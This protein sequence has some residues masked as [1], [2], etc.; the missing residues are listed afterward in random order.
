[1]VE[2]P[3]L[4]TAFIELQWLCV[5]RPNALA[6]MIQVLAKWSYDATEKLDLTG[7]ALHWFK[8]SR[9]DKVSR[10]SQKVCLVVTS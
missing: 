5:G 3:K 4:T 6:N 2:L 8:P 7:Q 1:M 9:N 10:R